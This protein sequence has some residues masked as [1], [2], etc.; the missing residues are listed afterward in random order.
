M[1]Q[2]DASGETLLKVPVHIET[3]KQEL[4]RYQKA[5]KSFQQ[6]VKTYNSKEFEHAKRTVRE[7]LS[8]KIAVNLGRRESKVKK[9]IKDK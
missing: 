7:Q 8:T 2:L 3:F 6:A 1:K 5:T 9:H 4:A